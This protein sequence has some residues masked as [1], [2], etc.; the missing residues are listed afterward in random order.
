[1]NAYTL[2]TVYFGI[3]DWGKLLNTLQHMNPSF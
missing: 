2:F 3:K 1:M